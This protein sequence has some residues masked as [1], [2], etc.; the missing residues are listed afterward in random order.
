LEVNVEVLYPKCAGLDVH[1]GNV[2]ACA[3]ITTDVGVSYETR[4]FSTTT[5][6]LLALSEW[7]EEKGCTQVAMEAT[8]VYWKPVWHMLAAV[9]QLVL[10]N[11]ANIKGIA[12]PKT[13]V[14]DARW[15]ADLLAHGLIRNSFVPD[16]PI[17]ELRDLTRTR[18]QFVQ[19]RTR[20]VQRI[21]KTLEDANVKLD[22]V[23]SNIVGVSGKAMLRA[24]IAGT[25]DPEK[26]AE[27]ANSQIKASRSEL[28]E[29]LRG[30]VTKHH[31]FMLATYLE[32]VERLDDAVDKI[33]KELEAALTPFRNEIRLLKTIPGVSAIS[34]PIILA[35]V[36][37]DMSRFPTPQHLASWGR[38][39]PRND[40]SAGKLQS[41]R[42]RKG[43]RW[44]KPALL[45][46]VLNA[47][48]KKPHN[49]LRAQYYRLK[50][51]RGDKKAKVAVA[52]SILNAVYFV[53]RDKVPYRDLGADY[54]DRGAPAKTVARLVQRLNA[55]GYDAELRERKAA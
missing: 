27:L 42:V 30:R 24:L 47:I 49:Y 40:Q 55:L 31:R 20:H 22:G 46:V 7:L 28:V 1:K 52:A 37:P 19:E 44:L 38:L 54:F 23:I 43:S 33:D 32:Q 16:E 29:A 21:Q 8:G 4:T 13:D 25:A 9:F 48:R 6:A 17:Q 18:K 35:E 51:R 50:A 36:G 39:C 11:A 53:L 2:V 41:T 14:C 45:Q 15:L 12:R 26:L 3:R 34:A 10:A 5:K